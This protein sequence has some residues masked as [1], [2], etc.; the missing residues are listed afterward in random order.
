MTHLKSEIV[1]LQKPSDISIKRQKKKKNQKEPPA[2][3][4][5]L[6]KING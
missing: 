3:G 1:C 5:I 4:I 2:S 6:I